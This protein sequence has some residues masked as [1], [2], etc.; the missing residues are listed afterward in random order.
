MKD[1]APRTHLKHSK[2]YS[3]RPRSQDTIAARLIWSPEDV[4]YRYWFDIDWPWLLDR[5]ITCLRPSNLENLI[6][7]ERWTYTSGRLYFHIVVEMTLCP[8]AI[9]LSKAWRDSIFRPIFAT[10]NLSESET[11]KIRGILQEST[12]ALQNILRNKFNDDTIPEIYR[13]LMSL[14]G[15]VSRNVSRNKR[16]F[17]T[18]TKIIRL[19]IDSL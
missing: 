7:I 3:P 14:L 2:P 9:K 10:C 4:V 15:R 17:T 12:E 16:L 5:R 8:A 18:K 19:Q 6:R 1:R 11:K 13:Q